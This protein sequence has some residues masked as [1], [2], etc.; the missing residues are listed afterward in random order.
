M[1]VLTERCCFRVAWMHVDAYGFEQKHQGFPI[2]FHCWHL[3]W[4]KLAGIAF[5][6]FFLHNS[7]KNWSFNQ[8]IF[9]C[10]QLCPYL[11]IH[12]IAVNTVDE[13]HPAPVGMY[14]NPV[15]NG[16]NYIYVH[17]NWWSPD[18]FHQP[19]HC[20][21]PTKPSW[22]HQ[23]FI[24]PLAIWAAFSAASAARCTSSPRGFRFIYI[25][26]YLQK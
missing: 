7:L 24:A 2:W 17:I 10:L 19:Y 6:D 5:K 23:A 18:F 15:N 25:Y 1:N 14:K 11:S 21:L 16:I 12:L 4:C 20:I 8:T 13:R 9:K 3:R 26:A 22:T